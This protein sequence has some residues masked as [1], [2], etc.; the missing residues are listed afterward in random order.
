MIYDII[1]LQIAVRTTTAHPRGAVHLLINFLE[2]DSVCA[3]NDRILFIFPSSNS[4]KTKGC[5]RKCSLGVL[6]ES[7]LACAYLRCRPKQRHH[8]LC[9]TLRKTG[10]IFIPFLYQCGRTSTV[11]KQSSYRNM[12]SF[13]ANKALFKFVTPSNSIEFNAWQM[14]VAQ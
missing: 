8:D 7:K 5:F 12:S 3:R 9:L 1:S 10:I 13:R 11:I 6:P 4:L 2:W 14:A